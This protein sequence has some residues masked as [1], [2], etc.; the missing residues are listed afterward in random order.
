MLRNCRLL[1]SAVVLAALGAFSLSSTPTALAEDE[2]DL[3]LEVASLPDAANL[4][5]VVF[6]VTNKS[7]FWAD[8][9]TAR[10]AT[11][12]TGPKSFIQMFP[13]PT[14]IK[15]DIFIENLDPG[16]TTLFEYILSSDC[17]GH[18]LDVEV[19]PAKSWDGTPELPANQTNNKLDNFQL[20]VSTQRVGSDTYIPPHEEM[21]NVD[22]GGCARCGEN[23]SP[24]TVEIP[25]DK[26]RYQ[27]RTG[28]DD[29]IPPFFARVEWPMVGWSQN[30]GETEIVHLGVHFDSSSL[31]G[32]AGN[33]VTE[34]RLTWHEE[35]HRWTSGGGSFQ[36]KAGCVTRLSQSADIFREGP[37][38][39]FVD[40]FLT[41]VDPSSRNV[42]LTTT[43]SNLLANPN[44]PA[45]GFN[46]VLR[47]QM[48]SVRGDD[49]TSCMSTLD[50]ITLHVT[51]TP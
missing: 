4:R 20:C 8:E 19:R 35:P 40:Q 2:P 34:A 29:V 22:I 10:V 42:R 17:D 7:P 49:D 16:Q 39:A 41:N 30:D 11:V 24:K 5:K 51:Y 9:T 37:G 45:Q 15:D 43:V 28:S 3:V 14:N 1:V 25:M 27:Q 38:G 33:K 18:E 32:V 12:F 48:D 13:D 6:K 36:G 50:K 31:R 26:W 46:F 44:H 21:P 23:T 47:G